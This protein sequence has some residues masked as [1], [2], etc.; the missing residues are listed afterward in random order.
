M[1]YLV[2]ETSSPRGLI[3]ILEEGRILLSQEV[4]FGVRE[5]GELVPVWKQLSKS[6]LLLSALLKILF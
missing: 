3:S 4:P 1:I 2:L 5:S 6:S